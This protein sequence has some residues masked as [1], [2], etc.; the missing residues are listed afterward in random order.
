MKIK[1]NTR[2]RD[3]KLSRSLRS[4]TPDIIIEN[5]GAES[6]G[7][8]HRNVEKSS[9]AQRNNKKNEKVLINQIKKI[10]NINTIKPI[11]TRTLLKSSKSKVI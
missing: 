8:E 1:L 7:A 10:I 11:D 9:I 5:L 3:I 2:C 6:K 4:L